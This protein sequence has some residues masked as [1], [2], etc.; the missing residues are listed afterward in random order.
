MK[1]LLVQ[2]DYK[3]QSSGEDGLAKK[4]LPARSLLELAARLEARGHR[5]TVLD[6]LTAL[7]RANGKVVDVAAEAGKMI[8]AEHFDAVGVAVYT[9]L[10]NEA[11]DVARAVKKADREA[12][13]IAGGPHAARLGKRLLQEWSE[14]DFACLGAAEESLP[15]LLD[16]LSGGG[17]VFRIKNIAYRAGPN[18]VRQRGKAAIEVNLPSLEPV[19]YDSYIEGLPDEKIERAYVMTSRGCPHWCN[20]CSNLWKKLL[21]DDPARVADEIERLV[22]GCGVEAVI[23]YDDCFGGRPEHARAVLGALIERKLEVELQA[24][25]RFDAVDEDW[26]GLFREAGGRD[27][28][29]GL[30]TGSR[31][32]RRKM[33][34]HIRDADLCR[35][36][37]MIRSA[38]LRLGV[39]LMVGF[40]GEEDSDLAETARLL[41]KLD[42]DQV[43]SH[44]FD[45]KPGDMLF[46]FSMTG[47][48][49]P[50]KF[51]FEDDKRAM[52]GMTNEDLKRNAARAM[53]F[54]RAFSRATL[55]PEHDSAAFNLDLDPAEIEPLAEEESVRWF[56]N[57]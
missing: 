21:L 52:N 55:L 35:G 24:V 40:P 2:P 22:S 6:P 36:A 45:I 49:I 50:E 48:I 47:K 31:K 13:V 7:A 19:R 32:L 1:V 3:R 15:A 16:H 4:L 20:F 23:L 17:P 26:L 34:K 54:D 9:S 25:T 37:E 41:R 53:A 33:N 38:G 12:S 39:W 8:E 30:E 28:L 11:R 44:V 10:R 57:G 27:I 43:M 14:F 29:A 51:W 18:S 46:E 5:A 42:P 56:K